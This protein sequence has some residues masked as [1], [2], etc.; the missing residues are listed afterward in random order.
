MSKE[1]KGIN[2]SFDKKEKELISEIIWDKV[3]EMLPD[4]P[5]ITGISYVINVEVQEEE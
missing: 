3:R 4:S 1:I 2:E 5:G